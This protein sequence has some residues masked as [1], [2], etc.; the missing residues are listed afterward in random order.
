MFSDAQQLC[1]VIDAQLATVGFRA[2]GGSFIK[3]L[4][5]G[6][7]AGLPVRGEL[8]VLVPSQH[9]LLGYVLT[10]EAQTSVPARWVGGREIPLLLGRGLSA[11]G[12]LDGAPIRADDAAWA[13]RFVEDPGARAALGALLAEASFVEHLP[14]GALRMQFQR[15]SRPVVPPLVAIM[16]AFDHLLR[17]VLASPPPRPAAARWT[18]Q[19]GLLMV[20]LA[21]FVLGFLGGAVALALTL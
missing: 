4:Y 7:L 3:R 21:I 9:I 18:D 11:V 10:L 20:V 13:H 12:D 1:Q 19:R 8:S 17:V 5:Q 2:T 16:V 14:S 6:S 15:A